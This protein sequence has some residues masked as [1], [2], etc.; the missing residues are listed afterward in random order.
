MSEARMTNDGISTLPSISG[1][2]TSLV[3]QTSALRLCSCRPPSISAL[4]LTG[5]AICVYL[6]PEDEGAFRGHWP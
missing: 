4:L 3:I 5:R 2:P 6:L 1:L